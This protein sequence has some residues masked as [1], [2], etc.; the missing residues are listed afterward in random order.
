MP[1]LRRLLLPLVLLA[2]LSACQE[3]QGRTLSSGPTPRE[4]P[5]PA[6]VTL[7]DGSTLVMWNAQVRADSVVG[8]VGERA[9]ARERVAVAVPQ[10]RRVEG[11]GVDFVAT[12]GLTTA[13][14]LGA[15]IVLVVAALAALSSSAP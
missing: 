2:S 12:V 13:V 10:V 14:T 6:R 15:I 3:W 8:M 7:A 9:D 4:L 5:S 11:R 1:S